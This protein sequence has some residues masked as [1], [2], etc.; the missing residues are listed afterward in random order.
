MTPNRQIC[1]L[2]YVVNRNTIAVKY[3]T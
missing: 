2:K 1:G 3:K